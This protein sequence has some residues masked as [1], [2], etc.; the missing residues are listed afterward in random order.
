MGLL[1]KYISHIHTDANQILSERYWKT[2]Y[3]NKLQYLKQMTILEGIE[4]LLM[5]QTSMSPACAHSLQLQ[6]VMKGK[7][8]D[9]FHPW[10]IILWFLWDVHP[11]SWKMSQRSLCGISFFGNIVAINGPTVNLLFTWQPLIGLYN[12]CRPTPTYSIFC[13]KT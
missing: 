1:F 5:S 4:S 12:F 7:L 9:Q 13:L 3:L 2:H 11:P 8:I 6:P 10:N